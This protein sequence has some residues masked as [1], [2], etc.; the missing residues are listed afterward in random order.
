M[1]TDLAK[2]GL[3]SNV[4]I[5]SYTVEHPTALD[6]GKTYTNYFVD[7]PFLPEQVQS[8]NAYQ[9]SGQGH[10]FTCGRDRCNGPHRA[11]QRE[12][13]GDFGQ[14]LATESGWV[15]PVPGCGYVQEWAWL[16]MSDW[17]WRRSGEL[18]VSEP[19]Q[20]GAQ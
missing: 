6:C 2:Q 1:M 14:L 11:Y 10:P 16:F 7:A 17:S 4:R 12:H 19:G 15:C 3:P 13:G 8:M 18:P 5:E 20:G 9:V